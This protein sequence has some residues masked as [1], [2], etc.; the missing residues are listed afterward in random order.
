MKTKWKN[1]KGEQVEV[2]L[3]G[4]I[5]ELEKKLEEQ[6]IEREQGEVTLCGQ[7]KEME[8][9]FT[10]AAEAIKELEK[11]LQER[12]ADKE[13]LQTT[14]HAQIK[15]LKN[16]VREK[17]SDRVTLELKS[18]CKTWALREKIQETDI[19]EKIKESA[20]RGQREYYERK[21][22]ERNATTQKVEVGLSGMLNK[23][24]KQLQEPQPQEK[25]KPPSVTNVKNSIPV[26]NTC[27]EGKSD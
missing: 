8:R 22:Q 21:Q 18:L 2:N 3:R 1:I 26:L 19:V 14:I 7:T 23:L 24:Y 10:Y 11:E 9:E 27:W 25:L 17:D 4:Q 20:L 13:Q 15:E 12:H 16:K 6:N 5:A